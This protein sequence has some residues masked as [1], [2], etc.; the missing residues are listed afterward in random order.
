MVKQNLHELKTSQAQLV[1]SEKLASLGQLTAGVAHEINNPLAF[2]SNN[3]HLAHARVTS[4]ARRLAAANW[5]PGR[6][7]ERRR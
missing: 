7:L 6:D 4:S 1:Q 5:L 3:T 2:S